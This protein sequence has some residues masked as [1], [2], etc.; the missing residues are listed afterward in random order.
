M[1]TFEIIAVHRNGGVFRS[2]V[3]DE[4]LLSCM[5]NMN[6]HL[7]KLTWWTNGIINVEVTLAD[8]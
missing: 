5:R 2:T 1:K 4:T 7:P 8:D 6:E 3:Q